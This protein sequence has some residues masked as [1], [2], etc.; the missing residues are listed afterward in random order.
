M[1]F[2]LSASTMA[3]QYEM[4]QNKINLFVKYNLDIILKKKYHLKEE[5]IGLA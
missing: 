5:K 2:F 3:G 1:I 4:K